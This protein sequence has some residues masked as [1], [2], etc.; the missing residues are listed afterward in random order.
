[1]TKIGFIGGGNM[2]QAIISGINKTNSSIELFVYEP[3]TDRQKQLNNE[4]DGLTFTKSNK[5]LFDQECDAILLA[6]KPQIIPV[7]LEEIKSFSKNSLLISIAAGISVEKIKS[8]CPEAMVV[9]VMPNTPFLVMEGCGG[10]T[11]DESMKPEEKEFV[12]SLFKSSGELLEIPEEKMHAVTALSGSGP[13][14]I[15]K[16]A[17]NMI[18][19]GIDHGLTLDE[20]KR[21]TAQTITGAGILLKT[22]ELSAE[23]LRINVTS[24]NGTTEAA[25]NKMDELN[26]NSAIQTGIEAAYLRSKELAS[27]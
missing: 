1:M 25:L 27:H 14:Y 10:I 15:F 4:F 24:P 3:S 11:F 2:A 16:I 19:A 20:A 23:Q 9:R 22:S 18:Q 21:L 17:E 5:E 7:V 26:L 8:Y 6:V 12:I 13:A